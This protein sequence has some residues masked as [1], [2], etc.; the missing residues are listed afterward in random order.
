[1]PKYRYARPGDRWH[2]RHIP[3]CPRDHTERRNGLWHLGN[4][5]G[6]GQVITANGVLQYKTVCPDCGTSSGPIPHNVASAWAQRH[7]ISW[8]R[9]N[10]PTRYEPCVVHGCGEDGVHYH[11]FA[12]RNTFGGEAD[13]WP[14]LPLCLQHHE[15]WHSRMDNYRRYRAGVS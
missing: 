15:E 6:L 14:V 10:E 2:S 8:Q 11:H 1:M 7:G 9:T 12:P 13:K 5:G 4:D 3:T